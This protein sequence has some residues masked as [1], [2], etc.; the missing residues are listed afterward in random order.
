MIS[1]LLTALNIPL[2]SLPQHWVMQCRLIG[3]SP[4][5]LRHHAVLQ[6]MGETLSLQFPTFLDSPFLYTA[7]IS[8][9]VNP[10]RALPFPRSR[11]HSRHSLTYPILSLCS[12]REELDSKKESEMGVLVYCFSCTSA[13]TP[14]THFAQSSRSL[15]D[16][17][18]GC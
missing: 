18:Q 16:P 3:E 15:C 4:H 7:S 1:Y 6:I 17:C 10:S 9:S 11:S 13:S 14:Y 5:L 12:K 8:L 2:Y